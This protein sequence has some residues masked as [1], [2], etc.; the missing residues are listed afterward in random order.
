MGG[1]LWGVLYILI[2]SISGE[3]SGVYGFGVGETGTVFITVTIG[4]LLGYLANVY[5]ERLY[6][7]YVH[8]KGQEARL[9]IACVASVALPTGMLIFAWTA[10]PDIPWIVPMIGLTLFMASAFVLY[11]VVFVYLADCYGPYASSALAGQSLCRNILATIF[12]LFTT[13]MFDRMTYK[14]ANTLVALIA[15]AMIPIPYIL[16]FYGSGIRQ[17][18]P[19]SKKILAIEELNQT[20]SFGKS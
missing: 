6:R 20:A 19:V 8:R 17:R 14:W 10:R 2:D 15:V 1:L 9:Y 16:F 5:Q 11:Q 7:K 4:S 18:S 3:F 13:Q 12:P